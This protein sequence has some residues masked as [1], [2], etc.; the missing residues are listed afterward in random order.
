MLTR[1]TC[2]FIHIF[3]F[4][5]INSLGSGKPLDE[6]AATQVCC[7]GWVFPK[8]KSKV[9]TRPLIGQDSEST[10]DKRGRWLA[11]TQ[12]RLRTSE[13]ADWPTDREHRWSSPT[14]LLCSFS[15]ARMRSRFPKSE[16][17]R[18]V[19]VADWPTVESM[20][21]SNSFSVKPHR[22]RIP[23]GAAL[24]NWNICMSRILLLF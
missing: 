1:I 12:N 16:K 22:V 21:S 4:I 6:V 17:S 13:A 20:R 14:V 9:W 23:V 2:H 5:V 19:K 15:D 8:E 7:G 11:R 3:P 24:S 10:Q 18:K